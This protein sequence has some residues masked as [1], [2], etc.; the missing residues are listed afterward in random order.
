MLSRLL[1]V[2]WLG[3]ALAG[4]LLGAALVWLAGASTVWIPL[5][6]LAV[7][8][9]G[10]PFSIS[11]SALRSRQSA[12]ALWWRAWWGELRC[13]TRLFLLHLPWHTSRPI[14]QVAL[15]NTSGIPVVLVHGYLCNHHVW[16]DMAM[17]LRRA[18]H[19]VLGV[20]LE[21]LFTSI[22]NYAPLVEQAVA[23][24]C[25]ETGA[26]KVA[27]LGHSMGGLAIRAWLRT[28]GAARAAAVITLGTPHQGTQIAQSVH[29]PNGRQMAWHSDWVRQLAA[30]E[31]PAARA[32][33]AIAVTPQDNIVYPQMAQVLD[34]AQVKVFEGRGHVQLCCDAEVTQWVQ[35]QLANLGTV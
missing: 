2:L 5:L 30:D 18:G 25:R 16:D 28:H 10:T 26:S 24:L 22:D 19:T 14:V 21:P 15:G 23:R 9:A 27:L 33:M 13:S 8:I 29:T 31:T 7:P 32:L 3:L 4:A 6:A 1:R 17:D 35:Q 11:V 34:G 20:D 12:G